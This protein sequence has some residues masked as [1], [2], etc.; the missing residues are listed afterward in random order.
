LVIGGRDAKSNE[1]LIKKFLAPEDLFVHAD[2]FGAPHCVVKSEKKPISERT[3][4]EAA[5][6]AAVF[7]RSWEA[8][9]N[10]ADVY[11][12]QPDQVSKAAPTGESIGK[13]AFMVYG[14][15]EWFRNV[16]LRIA[17]GFEE[18]PDGF[19]IVSGPLSAVK[20]RTAQFVELAPGATDKNAVA[21]QVLALLRTKS[22]ISLPDSLLDEVLGMIPNGSSRV[23]SKTGESR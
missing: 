16:D 10:K 20:T 13:G 15:R 1:Q 12:A 17:V 21:K 18:R 3:K 14:E 5:L 19:R 6:F 11:A 9:S 23:L 2:V 7:S 22:G 4:Q 8:G